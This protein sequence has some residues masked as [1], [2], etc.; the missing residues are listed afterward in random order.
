M[1]TSKRLSLHKSRQILQSSFSWYKKYWQK[2]NT[3]DLQFIE[4][5]LERL[6]AA[7]L[8]GNRDEASDLAQTTEAFVKPRQQ[9]SWLVYIGELILAILF[10]LVIAGIVREMWFEPFEI[11]TGSMRPT[12]E[13]KDHLIVRKT[14]FGL[15][16]PF[17]NA[18][19]YFDPK[20]V[21][22]TGVFVFSGDGI[23]LPDTT[24]DFFGII[25]YTKKYIK[26]AMGKP[27]DTLYFYGGK[28]YGIDADGNEITDYKNG[29]WLSKL[30]YI[31]FINFEGRLS[32]STSPASNVLTQLT[33]KQMNKPVGKII[34]FQDGEIRGEIFN[35]EK[36]V[37]DN[38]AELNKPHDTFVSYSDFWGFKN[39]GMTRLL[40]KKQAEE[41]T[42]L[43]L[44][45]YPEAPLYLE[46]RHTPNLSS[47]QPK[48]AWDDYR[49]LN[50]ILSP[51]VALVPLDQKH[52]E[53]LMSNM[54]TARFEVRN[55]IGSRY[56]QGGNQFTLSGPKF[57]DIPDGTYEFYYG[58]GYQVGWGGILHE[59]PAGHPLYA[60]TPENI[61]RLY[62]L[63]IEMSLAYEPRSKTQGA[64]PA[65]YAYFRDGD[66][67]TLGAPLFSKGEKELQDF[68]KNEEKK[69]QQAAKAKPYVAFKDYGPPLKKDGTLDKE[70]IKRFG[71]T[72]DEGHYLA[73]GDNHAMS[74]D[75]RFFGFVPAGNLKGSPSFIVWPPGPRWGI[76]FQKPYPIWTAPNIAVWSV[77]LLLLLLWMAYQR[78]KKKQRVYY[79][80]SH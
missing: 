38:P 66:L 11:P 39:F 31:P 57:S 77:A 63:G 10:A 36:W 67:Y 47:P 32:S 64:Y 40:T 61:Q 19:F 5:H 26:R 29:P 41:L 60:K 59:L 2:L 3:S 43:S 55:G 70:F 6:D 46:I 79:K 48:L 56:Q 80:Q 50:L 1:A 12:F 35:G 71:L 74:A 7:V 27:G 69:E 25:P 22:R 23:D 72:V 75:S 20:L 51:F 13:E 34:F 52:L 62:N 37:K 45:D 68:I 58:K 78:R 18:H 17:Q 33:L 73:L 15:N 21:Q 30:E 8:A 14:T 4:N 54:Y 42:D 16:A 53:T 28:L 76:P 49:R 65:R 9:K 44:K 24:S